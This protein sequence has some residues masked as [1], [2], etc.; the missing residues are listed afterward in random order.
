MR[1]LKFSIKM[2]VTLWFTFFNVVIVGIILVLL[3]QGSQ[4]NL[5][6]EYEKRLIKSVEKAAK[7]VEYDDGMLEIDIDESDYPNNMSILVYRGNGQLLYGH[8]PLGFPNKDLPFKDGEV[9]QLREGDREWY[10]YDEDT[11][12]SKD[13]YED[14]DMY[15]NY[16]NY[17]DK[18]TY[19]DVFWIRGILSTDSSTIAISSIVST[20][21]ILLPVL[22]LLAA[23]GG[24]LV[25]KRAFRPINH[26]NREIASIDSGNDLCKRVHYKGAKDEIYALTQSFNGMIGRLE[27]AFSREKQ[28]TSD[29]SHELRTP[30][31]VIKAACE[32]GLMHKGNP[33]EMQSALESILRQSQNMSSLV[34][35]LLTLA[36]ADKGTIELSKDYFNLSEMVEIVLESLEE[37]AE[38]KQ[39]KLY[40]NMPEEISFYGD[41]TLMMRLFINLV[42][43]G[44]VYSDSNKYKNMRGDVADR[45]ETDSIQ[46][47]NQKESYVKVFLEESDHQII[48]IVQDNGIGIAKAHQNKIWNRFYQV[49]PSRSKL[50][51]GSSGLGLAMVK[52]IVEIHGGMITL[53]SEEGKGSTFRIVLPKV[54]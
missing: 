17:E 3:I 29:A 50:K 27:E 14:D 37:Q 18:G 11:Y 22:V 54:R 7:E 32:Y 9:Q 33:L 43:N 5:Q 16:E 49:D 51:S 6:G 23:V 36:R 47:A 30:I 34:N 25:T 1:R 35:Q 2:K 10:V 13:L 8:L 48:C 53:E 26:L 15:S 42:S 20:A 45:R 24:Y 40:M 44:I 19:N 31:A 28:F 52:W 41:Q 21:F 12:K 38:E 39:V 4:S 46:N